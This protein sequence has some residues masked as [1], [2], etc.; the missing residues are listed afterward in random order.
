MRVLTSF[1]YALCNH[2]HTRLET[3]TFTRSHF[4]MTH[5][6]QAI[7]RLFTRMHLSH[8][9]RKNFVMSNLVFSSLAVRLSWWRYCVT[10]QLFRILVLSTLWSAVLMQACLAFR[11]LYRCLF[12]IIT[13]GRPPPRGSLTPLPPLSLASKIRNENTSKNHQWSRDIAQAI[14]CWL[15]SAESRV[16]SWVI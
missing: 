11:E 12:I 5:R 1:S 13:L 6:L 10:L 2:V 4:V 9:S 15:P 14:R 7:M 3:R 16:L 8:I